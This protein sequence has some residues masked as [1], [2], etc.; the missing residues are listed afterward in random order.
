MAAAAKGLLQTT[1]KGPKRSEPRFLDLESTAEKARSLSRQ[2]PNK[3]G[4]A[5]QDE[6][7]TI[8]STP[9][10][11][12]IDALAG[13]RSLLLPSMSKKLTTSKKP[14]KQPD[15]TQTTKK[16]TKPKKPTKER[17]KKD[18]RAQSSDKFLPHKLAS[19][20]SL[21]RP[22]PKKRLEKKGYLANSVKDS[23]LFSKHH[24]KKR[25]TIDE[26]CLAL[27]R[28]FS[29]QK[30]ASKTP[31]ESSLAV[32]APFKERIKRC[33]L[34]NEQ[35]MKQVTLPKMRAS[36]KSELACKVKSQAIKIASD[37]SKELL[38]VA[39]P[40]APEEDLYFT[41]HRSNNSKKLR[42]CEDIV[43]KLKTELSVST[44]KR[45]SANQSPNRQA[46]LQ[47]PKKTAQ[48]SS[49]K[50]SPNHRPTR[51]HNNFLQ[52]DTRLPADRL[53]DHKTLQPHPPVLQLAAKPKKK[54]RD[55][56]ADPAV[57]KAVQ[58]Q[59]HT[60]I[61]KPQAEE[62]STALAC[63]QPDRTPG[64]RDAPVV[65]AETP[66]S[67]PAVRWPH[68]Q[69]STRATQCRFVCDPKD[70]PEAVFESKPLFADRLILSPLPEVQD[71]FER[72]QPTL[73]D[74]KLRQ[75]AG[76]G[77]E[78]R[79]FGLPPAAPTQ[80]ATSRLARLDECLEDIPSTRQQVYEEAVSSFATKKRVK[81]IIAVRATGVRP[82][83]QQLLH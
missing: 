71:Y 25:L 28:D 82:Q 81:P 64:P 38:R 72:K 60:F 45:S 16:K 80:Q 5:R 59:I 50:L 20:A 67:S 73:L 51:R 53:E 79:L 37:C 61:Y 2:N 34:V 11:S 36:F 76:L 55:P 26:D 41:T 23:Q 33:L 10:G 70:K 48:H 24:L 54:P 40:A 62:R 56:Q 15:S 21:K 32:M 74:V 43:G 6:T 17:S 29:K 7:K 8:T 83:M 68:H 49:S 4:R 13:S 9:R 63:D 66:I 42:D 27:G 65:P 57:S 69:P 12:I 78:T 18:P 35:K 58:K 47:P 77:P 1:L 14:K 39:S 46:A 52:P 31:K 22:L 75:D 30:P 3:T 44:D 19:Q